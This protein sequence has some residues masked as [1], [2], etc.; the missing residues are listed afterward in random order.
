MKLPGKEDVEFVLLL[1]FTRNE[2]NPILAG[3]L[4]V[5]NDGPNYGQFVAFM[6]PKD[7]Q[8][9]G[10]E[11]I[12]ADIDTDVGISREFTLL[13]QEGSDCIRGNL[14]IVP[15][16][17]ETASGLVYVEPIYLQAAD[18]E[19]P[20][21][22]KVIIATDEK[23]VMENSVPEAVNSLVGSITISKSYSTVRL[24]KVSKEDSVPQSSIDSL[25]NELQKTVEVIKTS[26]D[27]LEGQI[28]NLQLEKKE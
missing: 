14:L 21:L 18:V 12:E 24:E 22:K 28:K 26:L 27:N 1:P 2:P 19:F 23:V 25:I 11:Q 4:A 7:R 17:D 8:V 6:F 10:P 13:C 15:I 20:A 5:G 3:W 9:K 16:S